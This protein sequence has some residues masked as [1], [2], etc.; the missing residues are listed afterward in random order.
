MLGL[1]P[2]VIPCARKM[3]APSSGNILQFLSLR[4][5]RRPQV[6]EEEVTWSIRVQGGSSRCIRLD[7]AP[8]QQGDNRRGGVP[9]GA[10]AERAGAATISLPWPEE[11]EVDSK[12]QDTVEIA[13]QFEASTA[14]DER[15][16]TCQWVTT[17]EVEQF[18]LKPDQ[19]ITLWKS[20]RPVAA[21][22]RTDANDFGSIQI[23]VTYAVDYVQKGYWFAFFCGLLPLPLI[24]LWTD[25][26]VSSLTPPETPDDK[27]YNTEVTT[28]R[29]LAQA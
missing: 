21:L 17:I 20:L 3:V 8:E 7:R 14:T 4:D 13:L 22:G 16:R 11:V 18:R 26:T 27:N 6:K 1:F 19:T 5:V 25:N 29:G 12:G 9:A 2:L 24:L 23:A 28:Q 10:V 15:E